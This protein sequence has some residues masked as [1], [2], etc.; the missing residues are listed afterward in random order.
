[1]SDVVL[2][3]RNLKTHFHT[4][5]GVVP[6]VDGVDFTLKKG[7]TLCVVGESGCGKSV[8]AYTVMRLIPMP[9][10]KVESGE[11]LYKGKDLVK[12]TENEMRDIRGNEIAM[13]FQEPMTSLNPVYTIAIR[14]WKQ[15]C[16]IKRLN[17]KRPGSV[18]SK[19]LQKSVF[20]MRRCELMNILTRCQ[21]V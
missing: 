11:I 13:I 12:L 17:Q 10:G 3:V 5:E 19:C 2:E 9:P 8:T 7:K 14:S 6:A 18:L 15:L 1:M 4:D 16:F 20:Q 21:E